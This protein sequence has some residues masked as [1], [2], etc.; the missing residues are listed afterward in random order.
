MGRHPAK[1]ISDQFWKIISN[2]KLIGAGS[3]AVS[4]MAGKA[5][6]FI[7]LPYL[8][9]RMNPDQFGRLTIYLS[10]IQILTVV[11]GLGGA[12]L[13]TVEY[14]R[15]GYTSARRLRATNL[16][17][18]AWIS[19]ALIVVA[20][21]VS[22]SVPTALP[23]A[24]GLLIVAVSC[25]QAI[26]VIELAYYRGAQ[27]YSIAIAGQYAFA[28]L[29]VLVTFL[30][31]ELD[32]P[33]VANRLLSIALAGGVVQTAYALELRRKSYE[34]ADRVARQANTSLIIRFGLSIFP[35]VASGWI[36]WNVDRF[37]VAGFLGVAATGVYGVA[38]MLATAPTMLFSAIS[39]QLQPF[40]YQRLKDRDFPGFQMVQV[41]LT[42]MVL[43]FTI[44]YFGLLNFFF[45]S[46]FASEYDGAKSLLP[47]LLGGAAAQA[48]FTIFS[49]AVFYERRGRS[50][51]WLSGS[52]L[53][54]HI[55]GLCGLAL[56]SRIT[57]HNVALVFLV[58]NTV[59]MLGMAWLSQRLI[60]QLRLAPEGTPN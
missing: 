3:L 41:S 32:S 10:V 46:L 52:A 39:N 51:S 54:V 25:V 57:L 58:S 2:R 4:D 19:V 37:A 43:V 55:A 15:N 27:I 31:F 22:W 26:N 35:H 50:I 30:A 1:L 56:L 29:N 36:R 47:A 7:I 23:A 21:I 17:L 44:G 11:I 28:V 20:Q 34:H 24:T 33:T 49:F 48:I 16:K 8:A 6:G 59:A 5:A 13:I 12:A 60:V 40:L 9:N 14:I 45:N 42:V 18:A 38:V 53:L